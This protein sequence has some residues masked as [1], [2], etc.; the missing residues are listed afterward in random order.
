MLNEQ[1]VKFRSSISSLFLLLVLNNFELLAV[2]L[3][4]IQ[5]LNSCIRLLL[6]FKLNV[7]KAS[8]AVVLIVLHFGRLYTTVG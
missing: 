5:F 6:V 3:S 7:S 2:Q 8:A 4:S 1:I